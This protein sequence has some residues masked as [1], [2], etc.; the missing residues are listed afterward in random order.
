MIGVNKSLHMPR[1]IRMKNNLWKRIANTWITFNEHPNQRYVFLA[2]ITLI[3]SGAKCS[4]RMFFLNSHEKNI[5]ANR[6]WS[7]V[8]FYHFSANENFS[9]WFH[10]RHL[11]LHRK[12]FG[13]EFNGIILALP[14]SFRSISVR[15]MCYACVLRWLK[16][17][18][19]QIS[20]FP[21]VTHAVLIV[22]D[23]LPQSTHYFKIMFTTYFSIGMR[24]IWLID[25]ESIT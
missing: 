13:Y 9:Y 20:Y 1:K 11:L 22:F 23:V 2:V 25:F 24:S 15:G 10:V 19:T 18:L 4:S 14:A 6:R 12:L 17:N 7:R 21:L 16:I 3:H 5:T 8:S